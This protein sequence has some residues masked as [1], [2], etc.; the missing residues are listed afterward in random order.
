MPAL[1]VLYLQGNP[2][3]KKIPHYRRALI[4]RIPTLKFLDD[5]PVFDEERECA[6]AFYAVLEGGA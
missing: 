5:R 6:E 3:V 2:C 4:A 1:A